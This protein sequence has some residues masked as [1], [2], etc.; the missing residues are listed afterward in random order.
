MTKAVTLTIGERYAALK[1]FDAFKGSIT[2]LASIL[3]D[4]KK[5]TVSLDEWKK[6]GRKMLDKNGVELPEDAEVSAVASIKWNE[7]DKATWKEIKL[8]S[9]SVGYLVKSIKEKSDKNEITLAD[10]ALINLNNKLK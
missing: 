2:E 8:E 9:E 6:A 5:L 4:V 10:L 7:D 3:D 1:I